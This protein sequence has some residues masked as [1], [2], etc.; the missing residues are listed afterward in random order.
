[1]MD[2]LLSRLERRFGRFAIPHLPAILVAGTAIMFVIQMTRPDL[3]WRLTLDWAAVRR[4]EVWR[5]VTYF[6]FPDPGS[7]MFFILFSLMFTWMVASTLEREWGAFRFNV[8]YGLGA[9]ATTGVAVLFGGANNVWMNLSMVMAFA[10]LY[11]DAQLFL[12]VIPIR[13]KWL[14]LIMLAFEIYG[15]LPLGPPELGA[16]GA[17]MVN[18]LVFF[19]GHWLNYAR[20]RNLQVRQAARRADMGPAIEL[21]VDRTCAICGKTQSSGAD[22]RVCSCAKCGG[23]ARNLCLEHARNH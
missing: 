13:A 10:T 5:L 11:P 15:S 4:G 14:A 2:R 21:P 18:Y 23:Q 1:M 17:A 19:A 12:L 22:I 6:F 16:I 7:S 3:I 9:L 8:F 20:S